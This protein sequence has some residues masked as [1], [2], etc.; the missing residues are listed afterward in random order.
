[1]LATLASSW[2]LASLNHSYFLRRA[3][4]T[5][6]LPDHLAGFAEPAHAVAEHAAEAGEGEDDE[7]PLHAEADRTLAVGR[8][9]VVPVV[10][11]LFLTVVFGLRVAV[12]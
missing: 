7:D 10:H 4:G 6:L 9:H 8:V 3:R 1:M 5:E 12:S 2:A 11:D